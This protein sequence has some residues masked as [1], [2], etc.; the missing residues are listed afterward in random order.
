MNIYW[1]VLP[2]AAAISLV[3][4]ASR[5]ESWPRIWSHA[6]RLCA[7][8]LGILVATTLILLLLNTQVG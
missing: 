3:Y 5:H 1:F 2:L 7:M 8:I 6:A 4:S